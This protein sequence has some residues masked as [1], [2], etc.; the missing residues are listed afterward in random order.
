MRVRRTGAVTRRAPLYRVL[1]LALVTLGVLPGSGPR[2]EPHA[3]FTVPA[4]LG[5]IGDYRSNW[6]ALSD[7][8]LSGLHWSQLVRIYVNRNPEIYLHNHQEFLA[9]YLSDDV[10]GDDFA[11]EEEENVE[12][13]FQ[14]YPVGTIFIK[15]NFFADRAGGPG[16]PSNLTI[17]IKH[18]REFDPGSN[19]WE[20]IQLEP[21]GKVL[22]RGSNKDARARGACVQ[23]HSHM[24]DRDF[25]FSTQSSQTGD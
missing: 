25:V 21:S 16:R 10:Y 19:G 15:E 6:H 1:C 13:D 5:E 3:G 20:F 12:F 8:Q 23:C 14:P 4:E 11:D 22:L 24:K 18:R 9:T 7:F 2:A 17:M